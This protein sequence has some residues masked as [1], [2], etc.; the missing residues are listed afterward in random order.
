MRR[1]IDMPLRLWRRPLDEAKIVLPEGEIHIIKDRCK[2]CGFCIEFCPRDV[3]E[4]AEEFNEKGY[5]PPKIKD[6]SKCSVCGLC[7]VICPE[8]CIYSVDKKQKEVAAGKEE[9]R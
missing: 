4:K 9:S 6:A 7:E 8:F 3:L 1:R 2:E 5:H